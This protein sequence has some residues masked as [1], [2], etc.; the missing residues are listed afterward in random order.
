MAK[1]NSFDVVSE[2]DMQEVD[3]AFGQTLKELKQRFDLKDSGAKVEFDKSKGALVVT[4]PGDFVG[5][6][7]VDVL[8]SKLVKRGID[9]KSVTWSAPAAASGGNV[10][11]TGT[12]V[13]GIDQDISRR[14]NKDV[15]NA[16]FK[17]KVTIEGEKLRVS[18]SSRDVLQDVI[19]FLK[20]KDYGIPL[21]FVNY[22]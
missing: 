9:L 15:K 8:Q 7:V 12:I 13:Q 4:A 18:S 22:R 17:A 20:D 11:I 19:A 3:N 6:Q 1:E 5:K 10:N 2:V 21:Q 16:K 14:I